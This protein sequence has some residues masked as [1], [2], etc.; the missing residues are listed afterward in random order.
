MNWQP[1]G[2]KILVKMDKVE[3]KSAGGIILADTTH[4]RAEMAQ[5]QGT[6]VAL[7]PLAYN[8]QGTGWVEVGDVV[9]FSKFAGYLHEEDGEKYR[10]MHDLDVI[11]VLKGDSNE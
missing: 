3:K 8:D 11:M 2:N 7:G 10:V 1:C 9:K 5:M 6:V 4:E